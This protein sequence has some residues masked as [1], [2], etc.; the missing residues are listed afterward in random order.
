MFPIKKIAVNYLTF[1]KFVRAMK[2]YSKMNYT[3]KEIHEVYKNVVWQ[4]MYHSTLRG[5]GNFM[6]SLL[7][8]KQMSGKYVPNDWFRAIMFINGYNKELLSY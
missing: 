2:K 4:G 7:F 3:R 8:D 6:I 5:K 1:H